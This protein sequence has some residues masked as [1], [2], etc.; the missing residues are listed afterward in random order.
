MR[1]APPANHH[2]ATTAQQRRP[3][4]RCDASDD[5]TGLTPDEIARRGPRR[6]ARGST[7]WSSAASGPRRTISSAIIP[8]VKFR[9]FA[10]AL[11]ADLT[12]KTVLD[13]GCNGGFYSIEMKRRGAARVLGIDFD[14]DY[15]AQARF[16]AEVTG[17]DIEF[18]QMSVYDVGALGER[19][20][21]VIFMGVLYHLRHPLLALD[22]IHDTVAKDLLLF[23]SLQ[24]GSSAV[25]AVAEDYDFWE[26]D[27][28]DSPGYPEDAF[29]RAQL[30]RRSD[31]LVGAERRLFGRHA[32]QRR[33]RHRRPS[34][35]RSVRLPPGRQRDSGAVYPAARATAVIEA[36][37][38]WN[39]PNNKSHW[40]PAIDP[41]WSRFAHMVN[42]AGQAIRAE[43]AT[44]PRVLGGM[45]PIDP[46][47]VMNLAGKG[48]L[49]NLDALAV[50]GFPLDWN[51]WPLDGLA[52]ED[53]RNPRRDEP[54]GLG[55]RGRRFDLWGRGGAGVGPEAHGRTAA[56]QGAP[57][58]LVF[59]LRPAARMGGHHPAQGGR[60]LVLLPALRH[61]PAPPGRHAEARR[62]SIS[63]SARP[64]SAFASGSTSRIIGSMTPW[65]DEAA[66]AS[67]ICARACPGPTGSGPTRSA[68]STGWC[69]RSEPFRVT[70]TFC[71]TPEH[72][73]IEPHHTSA[74][75]EPELFAEFC[76]AMVRRY[77]G[78]APVPPITPFR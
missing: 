68:G 44:L 46:T 53:R 77:V 10:D 72:L 25:D 17:Q 31:Q 63:T 11:P 73:G 37:M 33:L 4:E 42:L 67:P 36:A 1:H 35:G 70:V 74:P 60:G 57:H 27:H 59:A 21:L 45:S 49:D 51:L 40:D 22:I 18:R 38:I 50:H 62:A 78:S 61:G 16:A 64:T 41:D 24:R 43:N 30:Q 13:I 9:R 75:R 14:E 52:A 39:E 76:A 58:P 71:F 54:A 47:F 15:L 48:V 32:A 28:F 29:H 2:A 34:G 7:T 3:L 69:A 8:S 55:Q 19:F 23:Q 56:R 6:S 20:D 26:Q 65:L 12:G 66:W 5:E